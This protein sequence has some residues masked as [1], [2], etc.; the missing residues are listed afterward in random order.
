MDQSVSRLWV[1]RLGIN[2][3]V[4]DA[5]RSDSTCTGGHPGDTQDTEE[6]GPSPGKGEGLR[7]FFVGFFGDSK[8]DLH[9]KPS[10]STVEDWT[11]RLVIST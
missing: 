5:R 11:T 7:G 1:L 8:R 6:S 3:Q 9:G 10:P 4:A 2:L